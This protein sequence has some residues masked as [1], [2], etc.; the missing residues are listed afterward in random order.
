MDLGTTEGGTVE[1]IRVRVQTSR[2]PFIML[3][4]IILKSKVFRMKTKLSIFRSNLYGSE[5]WK[6]NESAKK[7]LQSL[8]E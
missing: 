3:R 2:G 4:N 5:W 7:R 6:L 1:D 8:Y